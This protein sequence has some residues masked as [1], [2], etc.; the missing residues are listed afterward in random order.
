MWVNRKLRGNIQLE[1]MEKMAKEW[2]ERVTWMSSVNWQME[3]DEEG[4]CGSF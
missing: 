3:V 1:K 4:W 2:I